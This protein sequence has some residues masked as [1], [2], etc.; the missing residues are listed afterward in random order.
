ML[1]NNFVD[2][3]ILGLLHKH[4]KGYKYT[5]LEAC[6]VNNW[7]GDRAGIS[8]PRT[9]EQEG[10]SLIL[11]HLKLAG[12]G[13]EFFNFPLC[14]IQGGK[15]EDPENQLFRGIWRTVDQPDPNPLAPLS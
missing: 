13:G 14:Q 8:V 15:A 4:K 2:L 6:V 7:D 9:A 5:S 11:C 1:L 3:S 10:I 12:A